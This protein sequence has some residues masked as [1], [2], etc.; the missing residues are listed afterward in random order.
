MQRSMESYPRAA[1]EQAMKVQESC[2][3]WGRRSPGGRRRR[4]SASA[5]DRC[6]VGESA[7]KK[8]LRRTDR[9][10]AR[11]TAESVCHWRRPSRCW[12]FY[13]EK[14]FDLNVPPFSRE[15]RRRARKVTLSYTWVKLALQ[16]A[17]LVAKARK[18]GIAPQAARTA[19][20]AGACCC[21]STAAAT[22]GSRMSAGDL[23]V[24]LD[25]A[26]SEICIT[27][28][29]WKKNRRFQ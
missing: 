19:P 18:R 12:G 23:I 28:S 13:R 9:P 22:S 1:V 4:S 29:W 21:T 7:M 3:R 17:G 27:P 11:P 20:A 8:W 16:G 2:E 10:A 26:T 6:G 25:D 5:T 14:Y 24:I 15:A